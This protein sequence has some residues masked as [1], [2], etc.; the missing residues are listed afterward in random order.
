MINAEIS[1]LYR[2]WKYSIGTALI[3]KIKPSMTIICCFYKYIAR[4]LDWLRL[5]IEA[6]EAIEAFSNSPGWSSQSQTNTALF[7]VIAT[8]VRSLRP[9]VATRGNGD[10]PTVCSPSIPACVGEFPM[11]R[12][13][14]KCAPSKLAPVW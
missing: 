1:V 6:M 11:E 10:L 12:T 9:Q 3:L 4:P 14:N 8:A 2:N 5:A 7:V 13:K